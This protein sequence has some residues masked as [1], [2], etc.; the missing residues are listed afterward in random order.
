[1]MLHE[2]LVSLNTREYIIEPPRFWLQLHF[3]ITGSGIQHKPPVLII[4]LVDYVHA[5]VK[6]SMMEPPVICILVNTSLLF[7]GQFC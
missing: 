1:M 2:L 7:H 3:N 4:S 5:S 6:R